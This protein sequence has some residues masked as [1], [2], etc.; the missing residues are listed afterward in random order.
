MKRRVKPYLGDSYNRATKT[1]LTKYTEWSQQHVH[2][3]KVDEFNEALRR[4][5]KDTAP[6]PDNV[7]YSDIKNLTE[8]DRTELSC[9]LSTKK[10][11]T[12]ATSQKTGVSFLKP[13]SKPGKDHRKQLNGYRILAMQNTI[14]K[15]MERIVA[16]KLTRDLEDQKILPA[17]QGGFRLGKCTSGR[18]EPKWAQLGTHTGRRQ[19]HIQNKGHP[20]GSRSCATTGKCTPMLPRHWIFHQ[21]KQGTDT[22]VQVSRTQWWLAPNRG[23]NRSSVLCWKPAPKKPDDCQYKHNSH[24]TKQNGK[25]HEEI[26][27]NNL[28]KKMPWKIHS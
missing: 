7:R 13:V 24:S 9:T 6:G 4:S 26:P 22:G 8:E 16:R 11:L 1:T 18:S 3:Q 17:N 20:G 23:L 28:L 25:K 14:G 15:L 21:S 2:S 27:S 10:A 12:K 19:A 5:G